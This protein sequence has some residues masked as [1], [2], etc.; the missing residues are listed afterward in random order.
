MNT[1]SIPR[2]FASVSSGSVTATVWVDA[3]PER[4]FQALTS[5]EVTQWWGGAAYQIN[6]WSA[7]VKADGLWH[8]EGQ[9]KDGTTFNLSGVFTR[10]EPPQQLEM[11][12]EC[13]GAGLP[14]TLVR[15]RLDAVRGG[16]MLTVKHSG[17]GRPTS[18][19]ADQ[20]KSWEMALAWLTD[21]ASVEAIEQDWEA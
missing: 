18:A 2:S 15:Y 16:T 14:I 20:A 10:V 21:Y 1:R 9:R 4:L 17:F 6:H 5:D 7:A 12:W 8:A 3:R 19:C 11:T 13:V